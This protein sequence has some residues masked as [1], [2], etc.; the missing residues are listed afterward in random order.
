MKQD[1]KH[2]SIVLLIAARIAAFS[3]T[4]WPFNVEID[5]FFQRNWFKEKVTFSLS[6]ALPMRY[7]LSIY[8][9]KS[10]IALSKEETQQQQQQ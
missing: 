10:E 4:V 7:A 1:R 9:I 3:N 6:K 5:A 8:R 2:S